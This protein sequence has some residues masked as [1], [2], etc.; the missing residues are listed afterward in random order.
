M[1]GEYFLQYTQN[2]DGNII[3]IGLKSTTLTEAIKEAN[4]QWRGVKAEYKK[5]KGPYTLVPSH[6]KLVEIMSLDLK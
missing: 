2:W 1:N 4:K 6:P 3:K 5:K